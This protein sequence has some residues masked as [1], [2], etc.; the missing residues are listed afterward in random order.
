[1]LI[2]KVNDRYV[3]ILYECNFMSHPISYK[4]INLEEFGGQFERGRKVTV[5]TK[6]LWEVRNIIRNYWDPS[7]VWLD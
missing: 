5:L 7:L 2:C 4:L 1:M 6:K 3:Q